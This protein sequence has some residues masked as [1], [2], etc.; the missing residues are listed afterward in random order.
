MRFE[1]M[2][3]DRTDIDQSLLDIEERRRTS[4][5]AWNGQ[6]SPQFVEA[7][8]KRYAEPGWVTYDPFA[9]SGTVVGESIRLGLGTIA[10]E[11]NPAAFHMARIRQLSLLSVGERRENTLR[12]T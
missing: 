9:G 6:F 4:L 5:F 2:G 12:A 8:L 7:M 1:D 3:I 11:L 10:T